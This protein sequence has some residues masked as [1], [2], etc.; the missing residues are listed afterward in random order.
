MRARAECASCYIYIS[1][2]DDC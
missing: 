1:T 2:V